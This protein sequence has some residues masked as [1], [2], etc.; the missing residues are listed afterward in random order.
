MPILTLHYKSKPLLKSNKQ[1]ITM[2]FT[3]SLSKRSFP[4]ILAIQLLIIHS[5]SSLNLTNE[6]LN[7]KCIL[8]Q[9]EYNSGSQ[10]EDNLNWIFREMRTRLYA[11]TGFSHIS[12]GKTTTDFV[13]V[14]TQCRG[15]TYESNCRT[16][17]DTAIAGFRK[18]C[19][20]NKGGI[21][22]YNQCL[23]YIS[24]IKE[25]IPIKTNYKNI[26]SMHN[27]N[28]V[29]GDAKLFAMRVMDFLSELI[30]KVEKTT[31]YRLIFYAAGEKKL[32]KNKLYAMVQCLDLRIDCKRC[33][34][35]SI[36]MLFKN[37]DIKQGAR[38]L[39]TDCNV[40]YELYPFLRS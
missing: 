9:G 29:R 1:S 28:N 34:A 4:P 6:Y 16:C 22:W 10:Y 38:V 36:T 19:P 15:D 11:I 40:R 23:L 24:T 12:V 18:R 8:N 39:G 5:V 35:W 3:Y 33:L 26:F 13:V 7:H 31:K 37:D 17:L 14:T 32:G 21:I 20:S 25:K 27:P 2:K 30:L